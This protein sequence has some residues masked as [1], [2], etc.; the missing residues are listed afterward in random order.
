MSKIKLQHLRFF[1]AVY[2]ERSITAA[3]RRVNA[4]QSGVSMQ[5]RDLEALLGLQ[6]F[7]RASTGVL[8]TKAGERIYWRAAKV[9]R[10]VSA[11]E[12]DVAQH[13]GQL[14]GMVR[15]GIM[16]TFA[17]AVLAPVLTEFSREHPF[18]DVKVTEGYSLFLTEMVVNGDLD[19]AV[20]PGGELPRGVRAT[21]IET[22]M[23]VLVTRQTDD[24]VNLA[25][26]PPMKLV[27]PGPG[28]ARRHRI[29]EYMANSCASVHSVMELD[30]M[31]TTLDMVAK[32]EWATILPGA[33]CYPDINNSAVG[34]HPVTAPALTV[35]YLMIE[36][37]SQASTPV[38]DL[39]AEALADEIRRV[40]SI[41]RDQF[42]P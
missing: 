15:V 31:M 26:A 21:F 8:P 29:D 24:I 35:D 37:A 22:D 17:R 20:V 2:E 41:C 9:L 23:E 40:C 33:L 6:L 3:A 19:F 36:S 10:E 38:A 14:H 12:A 4:T 27:L 32:G 42:R 30:S 7:E 13:S 11:L 16:P 5:V 18:I 28:N 25:S 39:F 1:V 34:L